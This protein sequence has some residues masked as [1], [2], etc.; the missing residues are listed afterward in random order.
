MRCDRDGGRLHH[1]LAFCFAML[2]AAGVAR[3]AWAGPGNDDERGTS[4]IELSYDVASGC[5]SR[6]EFID[7]VRAR[8]PTGG[9]TDPRRRVAVLVRKDA[10]N[11]TGRIS[12]QEGE[13]A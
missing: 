2:I 7:L 11:Y 3:V 12:S 8:Q 9:N 5:P 6:G 10:E 1:S 13:R 4:S